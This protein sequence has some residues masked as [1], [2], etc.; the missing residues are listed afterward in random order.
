MVEE[1]AEPL[2]ETAP[3]PKQKVSTP[4]SSTTDNG[5]GK[6]TDAQRRGR[7]PSPQ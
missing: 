4:R 5:K 6:D 3:I 2:K 1:M 7:N